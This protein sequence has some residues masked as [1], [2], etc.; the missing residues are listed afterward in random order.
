[1]SSSEMWRR[2]ALV[3]ADVSEEY[4]ASIRVTR[5]SKL[6]DGDNT[7]LRNVSSNKSHNAS[8]PR[9]RYSSGSIESIRFVIG[10]KKLEFSF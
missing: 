3:G 10:F 4:I 8:H 9:R 1:M 6:A 5:I 7:F 2:A